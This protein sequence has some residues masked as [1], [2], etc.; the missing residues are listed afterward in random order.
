[1]NASA[2]RDHLGTLTLVMAIAGIDRWVK[3]LVQAYLP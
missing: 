1:M 2:L 3:L